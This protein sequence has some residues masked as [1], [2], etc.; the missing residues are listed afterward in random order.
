MTDKP[1]I[2][3]FWVKPN[4]EN[5]PVPYTGIG[6]L[7]GPNNF[8]TEKNPV[9][10][11]AGAVSEW[12][13]DPT[14]SEDPDDREI[15][16]YIIHFAPGIYFVGPDKINGEY[17]QG[18]TCIYIQSNPKRPNRKV[19]VELRGAGAHETI[20]R[21]TSRNWTQAQT[22]AWKGPVEDAVI[23]SSLGTV[24]NIMVFSL[25]VDS[26]FKGQGYAAT[27]DSITRGYKLHGIQVRATSGF[28]A[29]VVI[30]GCGSNSDMIGDSIANEA[31]P[32]NI[33]SYA[34]GEWLIARCE[35]K[36][37]TSVNGG[38]ATM[39][40]VNPFTDIPEPTPVEFYDADGSNRATK[41][42]CIVRDCYVQGEAI[43]NGLGASGTPAHDGAYASEYVLFKHNLISNCVIGANF[44]T[45]GV[46][47]IHFED[48]IF[49]D[50][51]AM[52]QLGT[53]TGGTSSRLPNPNNPTF[54]RNF[55]IAGNT[56][57]IFR[58]NAPLSPYSDDRVKGAGLILRN[59]SAGIVYHEN[60]LIPRRTR[61]FCGWQAKP[62]EYY[63]REVCP[64]SVDPYY[65]EYYGDAGPEVTCM[66]NWQ[67]YERTKGSTKIEHNTHPFSETKV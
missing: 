62:T 46:R 1:Q 19:V 44:D 15:H 28:I 56:A 8:G 59:N 24:E 17:I 45:A 64:S 16:Q 6:D 65:D 7:P 48:N 11:S 2:N 49:V 32:L 54:H 63:F 14:L 31:F 4:H 43:V 35:V 29:D 36:G 50:V 40:S 21:Y 3:E 60:V 27:A 51:S 13:Y 55:Y 38:Y 58:H 18:S 53:P 22:D 26:N 66:D 41:F 52:I 23:R 30:V 37:F 39:I 67:D 5:V 33:Y 42:R 12:I 20:L 47:Y 25:T 61:K 34:P 10:F 57:I 9:I